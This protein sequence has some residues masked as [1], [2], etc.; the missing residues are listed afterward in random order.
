[1]RDSDHDLW[2]KAVQGDATP[3]LENLPEDAVTGVAR[4]LNSVFVVETDPDGRQTG[5]V[6]LAGPADWPT[7]GA[8]DI[9]RSFRVQRIDHDDRHWIL[10]ATDGRTLRATPGQ[11]TNQPPVLSEDVNP[12][13]QAHLEQSW[14]AI[15]RMYA[16][17]APDRPVPEI[18]DELLG[19]FEFDE[20]LYEYSA[21]FEPPSDQ[22]HVHFGTAEP[23]RIRALLP[24]VRTV[25]EGFEPIRQAGLRYLWDRSPDDP[26]AQEAEAEFFRE[27]IAFRLDVYYSGDFILNYSDGGAGFF[28]DG[29][30]M[31]VHFRGGDSTP[32]MLTIEG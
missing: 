31:A 5:T 13:Y 17:D 18:S 25:L 6:A 7:F 24:S 9:P 2:C 28:V 14:D 30:W 23:E 1:V 11:F 32:V 12:S 20:D 3:L 4:A 8:Q 21:T 22:V 10:H 27:A 16:N 26:A 29:Y 19:G 15:G